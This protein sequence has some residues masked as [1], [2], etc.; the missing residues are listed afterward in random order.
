MIFLPLG[1]AARIRDFPWFSTVILLATVFISILRSDHLY[2]YFKFLYNLPAEQTTQWKL[3]AARAAECAA[4]PLTSD[5][6]EALRSSLV[7]DHPQNPL[8]YYGEL[9][10]KVKERKSAEKIFQYIS[11]LFSGESLTLGQEVQAYFQAKALS[12][13]VVRNFQSRHGILTP[14]NR[15][16]WSLLVAQFS[17]GGWFHLI[18]NMIFLMAF[19]VFVEQYLGPLK[20]AA[21]YFVGGSLGL[22]TQ[23]AFIKV[24]TTPLVGA[25][26]N[27]F[28]IAGAFLILFWREKINVLVS[29]ALVLNK[30]VHIPV[31][32][33]FSAFVLINEIIGAMELEQTGVAHLAHLGGFGVGVLLG[34]H[35]SHKRPLPDSF[36]FPYEADEFAAYEAAERTE[37]RLRI[38]QSLLFHNHMNRAALIKLSE[39]LYRQ[40]PPWLQYPPAMRDLIILS[41]RD[42]ILALLE[43]RRF[44][45]LAELVGALKKSWPIQQ[46]L[47]ELSEYR[48]YRLEKSIEQHSSR[49][50]LTELLQKRGA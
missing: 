23:L 1:L 22:L 35:W 5:E 28:A 10:K 20:T 50:V 46:L 45:E 27:I 19:V 43:S 13:P 48:R 49:E 11:T 30:R 12:E 44:D 17:H 47:P 6:C 9:A 2:S 29:F 40:G 16:V 25:S 36:V 18:M 7:G 33:Y 15:T 39:E 37:D 42:Q 26:A 32:M 31:W 21:I 38:L 34:W 41:S 8:A 3:R 4:G 14:S 24:S